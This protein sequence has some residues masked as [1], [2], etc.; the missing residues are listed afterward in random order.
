MRFKIAAA[1][2]LA[3]VSTSALADMRKG[4]ALVDKGLYGLAYQE[5]MK[6]G[7]AG[8]VV[9]YSKAGDLVMNDVVDGV[10][11]E[12]AIKLFNHAANQ[13]DADSMM[14]MAFFYKTG[15]LGVKENPIQERNYLQKASQA[16]HKEAQSALGW[17]QLTSKHPSVADPASGKKNLLESISKGSPYAY[18][19]LGQAYWL[20][21]DGFKRNQIVGYALYKAGQSRGIQ[22][23]EPKIEQKAKDLMRDKKAAGDIAKLREDLKRGKVEAVL[24]SYFKGNPEFYDYRAASPEVLSQSK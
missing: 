11:P 6:A 20:G 5:F 23:E 13:G 21:V 1:L 3:I 19:R 17:L 14:R 7:K 24:A 9:G 22:G 8:Q 4:D 12:E 15:F 16:G 10:S 18:V 2:A